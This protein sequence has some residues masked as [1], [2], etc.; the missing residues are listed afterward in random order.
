MI[1]SLWS[2]L[3]Y[4]CE[5]WTNKNETGNNEDSLS[6]VFAENAKSIADYEQK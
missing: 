3:L 5:T 2:I 4:R 6:L 1:T